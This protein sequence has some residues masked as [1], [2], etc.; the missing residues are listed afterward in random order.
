MLCS[1]YR[2]T[3]NS[4]IFSEYHGLHETEVTIK[5]SGPFFRE[6][7]RKLCE[8]MDM[9]NFY[10]SHACSYTTNSSGHQY[11]GSQATDFQPVDTNF[12]EKP[13]RQTMISADNTTNP[14]RSDL[15]FA[16]AV[17]FASR[18]SFEMSGR[19]SLITKCFATGGSSLAKHG[20]AV[21]QYCTTYIS[22][23]SQ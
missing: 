15:S 13:L 18:I 23:T 21:Y 17:F 19:L 7:S 1:S 2:K 16:E 5:F 11:A 3:A 12:P 6:T 14:G 4:G 8:K 9:D 20:I 22:S 10:Y